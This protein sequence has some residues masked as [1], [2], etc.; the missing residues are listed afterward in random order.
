MF[1]WFNHCDVLCNDSFFDV[2]LLFNTNNNHISV[3]SYYIL[4]VCYIYVMF[5]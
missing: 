4:Y 5:V 2:Q 3:H 1:M